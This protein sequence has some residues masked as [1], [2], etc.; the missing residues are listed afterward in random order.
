MSEYIVIISDKIIRKT[1]LL[2][3]ERPGEIIIY[4][5]YFHA[6]VFPGQD[7]VR[8]ILKDQALGRIHAKVI[9]DFQ[10]N[11]RSRLSCRN[12]T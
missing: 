6:G 2:V 10:I 7:A 9:R 5:A 12:L 1:F 11:V 4:C 3:L 8:N